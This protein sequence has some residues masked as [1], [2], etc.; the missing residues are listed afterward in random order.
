MADTE[1]A[2]IVPA[3]ISTEI[4]KATAWAQTLVITTPEQRAT[5][6]TYIKAIKGDAGAIPKLKEW[7]DKLADAEIMEDAAKASYDVAHGFA[8]KLR[9]PLKAVDKALRDAANKYDTEQER[10][11][12]EE[13]RRLN[14]IAQEKARKE[15]ERIDAL[16]RAQREK[17]E[18]ARKAE[19]EARQRAAEA[20]NEE[21]RK[22]ALAEA[23]KARKAAEA[24]SAKAA[25][26]EEHA[27]TLPPAPVVTVAAN[28]PKAAG[29]GTAKVWKYAITDAAAIPR[30]YMAVDETKIGAVVRA[31]KGTLQIPGVRIYFENQIRTRA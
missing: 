23:E 4:A 14:A 19:A 29:E 27:A 11:R 9:T 28:A 5:V 2:V 16:A 25:E 30:E 18:A 8:L 20:A 24:A 1:T 21:A 7:K 22:I 15:Q 12:A 3:S 26:R 31:T 6:S 10:I 13:E 17:E